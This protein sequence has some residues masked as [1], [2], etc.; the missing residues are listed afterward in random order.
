MFKTTI[1]AIMMLMVSLT[2]GAASPLLMTHEKFV[3]LTDH[4][5]N[6]YVIKLMELSIELESRYKHETAQNGYS[7]ERFERYSKILNTLR[8]LF[9]MDAAYASSPGKIPNISWE[10][11]ASEFDRLIN[12]KQTPSSETCIFA[13]WVSRVVTVNGKPTCTHPD[14]I[15]GTG[16]RRHATRMAEESRG[17][18]Y[19]NSNSS[20]SKDDRTMIQCNPVIFGYKNQSQKSLFCVEARDGAKNSSFNCMQLALNESPA[21]GTDSKEDRLKYLREKLANT[22]QVFTQVWEF[23]YKTCVC[24]TVSPNKAG[25]D[26]TFSQYYQNHIRPHRTCYGLMEMMA[27]TAFECREPPAEFPLPEDQRSILKSLQETMKRKTATGSNIDENEADRQYTNFL[28]NLNQNKTAEYVR[29]CGGEVTTPEQEDEPEIVVEARR[30]LSCS[31]TCEEKAAVP[32]SGE[33]PETPASISCNEISIMSKIGDTE[34]TAVAS[35]AFEVAPAVEAPPANKEQ[36]SVKVKF[37]LKE[38]EEQTLDC[39]ITFKTPEE[40]QEE[41]KPEEGG[42][43]LTVTIDNCPGDQCTVKAKK[44][45]A[46]GYDIVWD[47]K[48]GEGLTLPTKPAKN[49][50]ETKVPKKEKEYQVC[51]ALEKDGTKSNE[52]C[53]PIPKKAAVPT[54][55]APTA[56]PMGGPNM[57]GQPQVPIRSTSDTSAVGIK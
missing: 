29:I 49:A 6:Q 55:T 57:P 24:P 50:E 1:I 43:K 36:T 14:F 35:D 10:N 17:Y 20:C 9:W 40:P 16:S 32:A 48:G 33:T 22:P 44:E 54:P 34:A 47:F 21:S 8:S 18:P 5:K 2:L 31:G 15:D 39:S 23:T 7:Q 45:N 41:D 46:E 52:D 4:E 11:M 51:A 27:G 30:T 26:T 42:P 19:P 53:K 25:G 12:M 37:K 56:A 28:N 38:K 13:G 3:H